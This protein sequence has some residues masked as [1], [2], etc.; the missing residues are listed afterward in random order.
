MPA[1][2][3]AEESCWKAAAGTGPEPGGGLGWPPIARVAPN[4]RPTARAATRPAVSSGR[5]SRP[6]VGRAGRTIGAG[7]V[8]VGVGSVHL[9]CEERGVRPGRAL[10]GS[11]AEVALSRGAAGPGRPGTD[12]AGGSLRRRFNNRAPPAPRNSAPTPMATI[13]STGEVVD[14]W[15]A[16]VPAFS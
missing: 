14:S 7:G 12:Q 9:R 16:T 11:A 5:A 4:V 15:F 8:V 2:R 1:V 3:L 10:A 13:A 6:A